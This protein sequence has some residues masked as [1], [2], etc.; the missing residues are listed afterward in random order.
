MTIGS[1]SEGGGSLEGLLSELVMHTVSLQHNLKRVK[2]FR[3]EI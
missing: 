2:V 1:V 3:K